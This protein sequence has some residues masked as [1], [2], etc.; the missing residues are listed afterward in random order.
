MQLSCVTIH[1]IMR[2][3]TQAKDIILRTL[4]TCN[5][6]F[7]AKTLQKMLPRMDKVTLY[8]A[9]T[10]LKKEDQIDPICHR[11]GEQWYEMHSHDKKHHHHIVCTSCEKIACIPCSIPNMRVRGFSTPHH[12]AWFEALCHSCNK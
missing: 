2:H 8:R 10:T 1:T 9:L 3:S 6:I 7:S 11:N 12:N 5:H 4:R